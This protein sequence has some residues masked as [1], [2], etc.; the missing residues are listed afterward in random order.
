MVLLSNTHKF[1]RV[2]DDYYYLAWDEFDI[3]LLD[4][5][6][7]VAICFGKIFLIV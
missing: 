4:F 3:E 7:F 5:Y 2:T 6:R 1:I